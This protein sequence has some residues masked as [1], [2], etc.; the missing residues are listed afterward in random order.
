MIVIQFDVMRE[1]YDIRTV[2]SRLKAPVYGPLFNLRKRIGPV[3]EW[4]VGR[5]LT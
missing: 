1:P 5:E 2:M 4:E 3:T